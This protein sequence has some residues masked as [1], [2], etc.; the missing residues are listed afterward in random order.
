MQKL[1]LLIL[2]FGITKCFSQGI[3]SEKYFL[4]ENMCNQIYDSIYQT[5]KSLSQN[6]LDSLVRRSI[7]ECTQEYVDEIIKTRY[8][9]PYRVINRK[10]FPLPNQTE[11]LFAEKHYNI[12]SEN[13][14]TGFAEQYP[15]EIFDSIMFLAISNRYGENIFKTI[16]ISSDSL[17]KIGKGHMAAELQGK[18]KHDILF[19]ELFQN[20][21]L[22]TIKCNRGNIFSIAIDTSGE[23]HSIEL[24][25]LGVH[26]ST[27][28]SDCDELKRKFEP[29]KEKLHK[30]KWRPA[31]FEGQ[32]MNS[33][34][35]FNFYEFANR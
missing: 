28:P 31:E 11:L 25:S 6:Y 15:Y 17:I 29:L 7:I 20:K 4:Y 1:L 19:K 34:L 10:L 14:N 35:T 24:L 26:G 3:Q 22:D 9:Y 5:N 30:L 8:T 33:M 21:Y 13:I 18:K 27:M 23:C 32:P 2:I 16:K 12:T